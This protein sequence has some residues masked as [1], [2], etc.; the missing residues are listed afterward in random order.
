[1]AKNNSRDQKGAAIRFKNK[2]A[3]AFRGLAIAFKEETTLLLYLIITIAAVAVGIFLT[4]G[5]FF[6]T[7]HW[8][9]LTLTIG[10]VVG[11]EL[12]NT[13]IENFVDLLSFEYNIKAKKIKDIC[14]AASVLNSIAAFL[15]GCFLFIEPILEQINVWIQ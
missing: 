6:T 10:V 13:A 12:I 3:N 5:G 1:M 7:I 2:F 4:T 11:F 8:A 15:V 14:A 9:I